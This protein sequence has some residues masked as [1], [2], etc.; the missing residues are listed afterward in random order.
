MA[1]SLRQRWDTV[2]DRPSTK[3]RSLVDEHRA[4]QQAISY[5]IPEY[6]A[7]VVHLPHGQTEVSITPANKTNV[8][9][10]R[11][12]F[13]PLLDCPRKRRTVE[14][15]EERDKENRQR[16]AKRAKQRVRYLIKSITAD[17]MLTFSYREN[18]TDHKRLESDWKEFVRLYRTR[19]PDWRYIAVPE[20]QERGSLHL[21][22]AVQGKQDIRWLLRCWLLAIGQPAD[23]VRSWLI[24][25]VKLGAK[26]LG[27]VNVEP[28]KKR[29]GGGGTKWKAEKLS[30][31][32]T[33][34]LG[35]DFEVAEKFAK[36]Y[37]HSRN[38]EQ[39][40]VER[41]W[42][43]A[44]T[45]LEAIREAHDLVF[46]TGATSLSMWGDPSAQVIWITGETAREKLGQVI[47]GVPDLEWD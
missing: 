6:R 12:G 40:V 25:H 20:E 4:F 46:Y 44:K 10:A 19:Y 32:L 17:Y 45:Y 5:E 29:W 22:V 16:S 18:M 1:P 21:H 43:R 34:Y 30:G 38:I 27:A 2:N 39:P 28:P 8:I 47:Q 42:L 35:K 36:K 13:N 41:F 31:Y 33:K 23:D 24:D 26:S 3:R 14:E 37:W 7:K 11:M 9:N 15:Q